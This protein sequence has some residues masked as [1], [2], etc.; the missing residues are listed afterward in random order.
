VRALLSGALVALMA[1][2]ASGALAAPAM[3]EVS[4]ADSKVVL[5]GSMHV[6]PPDLVWRTPALDA[7]LKVSPEVYFEADI[8]PLG[9]VSLVLKALMGGFGATDDWSIKL[10]QQQRDEI[11]ATA[12][13]L[14]L[15]FEQLAK[16]PPWLAETVIEEKAMTAHGYKAEAGVDLTLQWELPK[17]RKAYFETAAAQI[18]MLASTPEDGQITRFLAA[19]GNVAKIGE[20]LDR[21]VKAWSDGVTGD[22]ALELANDPTL[23]LAFQQI[24]LF[25]RNA[26]WIPTI[27]KLLADNHEDLIVVGAGHLVGDRSVVD[28]LGKAGFTVERIQ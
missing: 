6:L 2:P 7:V 14:G 1:I 22:I 27:A 4:D 23:D 28:L 24:M 11:D 21:L 9:Q 16:F 10:T 13:P 3:W 12:K 25:N 15:S 17:E 5:L 26:S 18:D 19:V 8:G 20:D